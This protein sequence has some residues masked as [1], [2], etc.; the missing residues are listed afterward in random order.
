MKGIVD[1]VLRVIQESDHPLTQREVREKLGLSPQQSSSALHSLLVQR[2]L[3]R[4]GARARG[5]YTAVE[6]VGRAPDEPL[7][8]TPIVPKP[9]VALPP[10][11]ELRC[12]VFHDSTILF[13][14][15]GAGIIL[16]PAECLRAF[17]FLDQMENVWRGEIEA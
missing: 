1:N 15:A 5:R 12:A 11:D 17:E 9:P 8:V 7:R 10:A 3:K 4:E 14:K 2:K 13:E 6:G 16:T